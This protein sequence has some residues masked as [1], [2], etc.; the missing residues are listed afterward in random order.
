MCLALSA[1]GGGVGSSSGTNDTPGQNTQVV[2]LVGT[3][4]GGGVSCTFT[5]TNLTCDDNGDVWVGTYSTKASVTPNTIDYLISSGPLAQYNG[6]TSLGLI[7]FSS[8]QLILA[9]NEPGNTTRPPS[10]ASPGANAQVFS[11][12][13]LT[14]SISGTITANGSPLS[15]VQVSSGS[16][17]VM[18]NASGGYSLSSLTSGSYTITPSKTGYTFQTTTVSVLSSNLTS[19]NFTGAVVS[20]GGN[21]GGAVGSYYPLTVGAKWTYSFGVGTTNPYTAYYEIVTD[22]RLK[23]TYST[24]SSSLY[25]TLSVQNN[26]IYITKMD[27]SGT[28]YNYLYTY[29]PSILVIPSVFTAGNVQS[30]STNN[31]ITDNGATIQSSSISGQ[32]TII[33]TESVTVSAGTFNCIK[34]KNIQTIT[35]TGAPNSLTSY[36]WLAQ[37]IGLVKSA[38]G[39]G[40]ATSELVSYSGL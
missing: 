40:A 37:N 24:N 19:V 17:S 30:Y 15:G 31:T 9:L 10:V 22:G 26:G 20:S 12:T 6:K 39:N 13:K 8:N 5:T 4:T 29:S 25:E 1:C 38:D 32:L 28:G 36:F 18:T 14:Y 7:S 3:W 23:I 2:G 34:I 33:G 21:T 11:L 16:S 27:A 35:S